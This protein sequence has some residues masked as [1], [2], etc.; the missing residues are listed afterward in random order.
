M[1]EYPT[2]QVPEPA[3]PSATVRHRISA[4]FADGDDANTSPDMFSIPDLSVT[5]SANPKVT[6]YS[7]MPRA[8]THRIED[9]TGVYDIDG[10]LRLKD[11][12]GTV[13]AEKDIRLLAHNKPN[14]RG[15]EWTATWSDPVF[16]PVTFTLSPSDTVDLSTLMFE[17][18]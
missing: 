7:G 10:D 18:G 13:A 14:M 15:F 12:G 16:Q 8:A 3:L 1:T 11:H 9:V 2:E 5:F 4:V 6:V 17:R